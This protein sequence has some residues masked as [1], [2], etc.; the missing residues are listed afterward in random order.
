VLET[1]EPV[2]D[3]QTLPSIA[4]EQ[5]NPAVSLPANGLRLPPIRGQIAAPETP[6]T[7]ASHSADEDAIHG[8][9]HDR[10]NQRS[11]N[12]QSPLAGHHSSNGHLRSP[13]G[14]S[15][16]QYR[17]SQHDVSPSSIAFSVPLVEPR[18]SSLYQ[19]DSLWPNMTVKESKLL[20][21]FVDNL[22]AWVILPHA[23][24]TQIGLT[25]RY[26]SMRQ[27][28]DATLELKSSDVRH[29]TLSCYM[30]SWHTHPSI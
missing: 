5:L 24:D 10:L 27:T 2:S 29:I 11:I 1:S 15:N 26:R 22:A 8:P 9:S 23:A 12:T 6:G 30:L 20:R 25:T 19:S 3:H 28:K 14:S 21:H 4:S 16:S 7:T 18:V 17:R 13:Y